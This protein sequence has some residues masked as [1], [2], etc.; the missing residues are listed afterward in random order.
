MNY[1]I[2]VWS[3]LSLLTILYQDYKSLKNI[4]KIT[5]S[6]KKVQ[7]YKELPLGQITNF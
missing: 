4:N 2:H 7:N 3:L 5:V 6:S 1:E